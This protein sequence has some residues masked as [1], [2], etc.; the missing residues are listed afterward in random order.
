MKYRDNDYYLTKVF[1]C[2][3]TLIFYENSRLKTWKEDCEGVNFPCI[4]SALE[5]MLLHSLVSQIDNSFNLALI[6]L[7]IVVIK[8][9]LSRT[10]RPLVAFRPKY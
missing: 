4:A 6:R 10:T 5:D 2:V 9:V 3:V 1:I 7:F 8:S